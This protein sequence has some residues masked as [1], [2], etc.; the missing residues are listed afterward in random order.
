MKKPAGLRRVL[1]AGA[2]S[3]ALRRYRFAGRVA[4]LAGDQRH[5]QVIVERSVIMRSTML[6]GIGSVKDCSA[7]MRKQRGLACC[8]WLEMP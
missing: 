4:S 1:E 5:H 7:Q 6:A 2:K 3:E 8:A